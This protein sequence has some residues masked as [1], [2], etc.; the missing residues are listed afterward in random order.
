MQNP[1]EDWIL[2][3]AAFL[4]QT[5]VRARKPRKPESLSSTRRGG[6]VRT[7]I[8]VARRCP[9]V[10]VKVT[11]SARGLRGIKEHLAYITRNG[12]IPGERESGE[13]MEG[14]REVRAV[15][16]EWWADSGTGRRKGTRDTINLILSM[17]PGIDPQ[18]VAEAARA[19]AQKTFGGDHDYLLA[20]H[21]Q[22]SDP[23]RPE[24]PH[25]HLTIKTRGYQGQWLN[26]RKGDLQAWREAFAAELRARN[27]SAE[28]TPRRA[29]GVVRKGKRQSIHHMDQ[30]RA[31][32]VTRWKLT[33]A[34]KTVAAGEEGVTAEPWV[35]AVQE[36]QRKIRR[37]WNTLAQAFEQAGQPGL[38]REIKQ[39]VAAMPLP[40][41]EREHMITQAR[42]LLEKQQVRDRGRGR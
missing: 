35:K 1:E 2:G 26:P 19:F 39:F 9:E 16:E 4:F 24:N 7:F 5:P 40:Q 3:P 29:R 27:V 38:A 20:H 15:A 33:Q 36:R 8:H 21:N 11:G 18:A 22:V 13:S 42:K 41:T 30:R 25:A 14:S 31:S 37:A 28:A 12:K 23:K 34:I 10:M 17:P 6:L 32:R